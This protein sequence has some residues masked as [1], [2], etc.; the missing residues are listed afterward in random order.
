MADAEINGTPI[1]EG[2]KVV[3][4]FV[5]AN[6]DDEVFPDAE[7]FDVGRDPNPHMAFGSGGPR[8]SAWARTSRAWR[9]G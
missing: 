9:S 5:S 6:Y 7:R 4:W 3:V 2:D 1:R 8:T